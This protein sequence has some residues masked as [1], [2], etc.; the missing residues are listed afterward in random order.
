MGPGADAV[1]QHLADPAADPW[2]AQKIAKL[3]VE[4]GF[5]PSG[6]RSRSPKAR[7]SRISASPRRSSRSLK[8]QGIRLASTISAPAIRQP[9]A[10]ARAAVRP[11]Q[12]RPQLRHVDQRQC[13]QR[14]DRQ[15][16]HPPGREPEPRRSPPRGSRTSA[17][18]AR[19]R[20]DRPL[21][22][23]GLA[24]RQADAGR[25]S[26]ARCSPSAGCCPVPARAAAAAVEPARATGAS[27]APLTAP[28]GGLAPARHLDRARDGHAAFT[29]C[30]ASATTSS[31]STRARSRW[32]S[33]ARAPARIA[34][35]RTG[36]GCDQL[37]LLEP[38]DR[39]RRAHAHLQRRR[40]RGRGLR[41]RRALRRPADR[42]RRHGSR[43]LGGMHQRRARRR[44][45]D[46]R[47]GRAALR[48]GR[49]PARLRDGHAR[50]CRSA[51]RSSSDPFAVN[52]GNPAPR[53]LRRPMPTRS[54]STG[55]AR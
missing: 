22:G 42:R 46:R 6:S 49:D 40:R 30:M 48:L 15:R 54:T 18:E 4:T 53:L 21:Q 5:P 19:L 13:R 12:D 24:L 25:R 50:R 43:P 27:A 44:R 32:R 7:C 31:S 51:G 38:S 37:I 9:R 55:S 17:I 14:R 8:N 16:H 52:V 2:L 29:R 23:P 36:I 39:R 45:R 20:G 1:G 34:D 3:L 35:R 47:H 26:R 11:D 33:T 28:H 41:Q 10:P